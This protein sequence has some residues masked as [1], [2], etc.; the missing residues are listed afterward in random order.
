MIEQVPNES[1]LL[2]G[3]DTDWLRSYPTAP[4]LSEAISP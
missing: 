4:Q 3:R 1:G 2:T